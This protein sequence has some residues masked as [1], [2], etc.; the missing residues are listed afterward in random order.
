MCKQVDRLPIAK[1]IARAWQAEAKTI[2]LPDGSVVL[3]PERP[4]GMRDEWI[5]P[6]MAVSL[7]CT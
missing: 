7:I 6:L 4:E 3:V 5:E 1:L 2:V